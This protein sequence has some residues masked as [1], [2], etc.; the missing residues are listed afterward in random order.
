MSVL[1]FDIVLIDTLGHLWHFDIHEKKHEMKRWI[2]KT[3]YYTECNNSVRTDVYPC[4]LRP[5]CMAGIL[6]GFVFIATITKTRLKR[7]LRPIQQ[8]QSD[9]S[10]NI[11]DKYE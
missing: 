8:T 6:P 10:L 2:A 4:Q 1:S 7:K 3:G 11:K 5:S 9:N